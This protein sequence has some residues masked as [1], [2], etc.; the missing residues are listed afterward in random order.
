ME[1]VTQKE[2]LAMVYL[3]SDPTD[4]YSTKVRF[5][6]KTLNGSV[7][8]PREL[9]E[10]RKNVERTFTGLNSTTGLLQHQMMQQFCR[11]T[12]LS[13]CNSNVTQLCGN[14][15]TADIAAAQKEVDDYTGGDPNVIAARVQAL[16]DATNKTMDAYLTE[17]GDGAY[18][19][20]N[21]LNQ[22]MTGLLPNKVLQRVKCYLWRAA[23]K[24]FD[25]S[26]KSSYMNIMRMNSEEIPCLPSHF[27]ETQSLAE[28]EIVDI[29]LYGTP[30]SWASWQREMDCQ[31]F[32]PLTQTPMQVIAFMEQY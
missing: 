11:G 10:W 29:L 7:E 26:I 28:Y 2:D 17:A 20:N 12:A 5:S 4:T 14:G 23:R 13:T 1:T 18:M 6:F 31:G 3:Y 27:T 19:V 32:D 16:T 21:A 25:M 22:L 15:K 9:I 30:K 24:P 8:S